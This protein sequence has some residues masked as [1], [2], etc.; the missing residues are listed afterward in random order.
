MIDNTVQKIDNHRPPATPLIK[1]GDICVQLFS[2]VLLVL[3]W[4]TE[5]L[6]RITMQSVVSEEQISLPYRM[7]SC[8]AKSLHCYARNVFLVFYRVLWIDMKN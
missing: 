1:T 4:C 5:V 6:V 7:V 2:G 3:W 8:F